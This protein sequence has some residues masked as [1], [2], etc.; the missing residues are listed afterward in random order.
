MNLCKRSW[1]VA[2]SV[3]M[4]GPAWAS[5]LNGLHWNIQDTGLGAGNTALAMRDGYTWP[6]VFTTGIGVYSMFPTLGSSGTHWFQIGQYNAAGN[7]FAGASSPDGR[8]AVGPRDASGLFGFVSGK[9]GGWNLLPNSPTAV[10][11]DNSGQ[12]L[13]GT[14]SG[15]LTGAPSDPFTN[16]GQ[17][18]IT[19]IATDPL[20]DIAVTALNHSDQTT[21]FS[22]YTTWTGWQSAAIPYASSVNQVVLDDHG[23][24]YVLDVTQNIIWGFNPE[25]GHWQSELTIGSNITKG[26]EVKMAALDNTVG[27]AWI[28]SS[29]NLIYAYETDGGAWNQSPVASNVA[30]E[31]IGLAFDYKDQPV[32]SYAGATDLMLAYD[33]QMTPEPASAALMLLAVGGLLLKRRRVA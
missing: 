26:M 10:A 20:G 12:L 11:F 33:P 6:V 31:Q 24:P 18:A 4:A 28:D 14:V 15:A 17:A 27:A 29:G 3:L 16:N 19:S 2:L 13:V 9:T 30:S 5:S 8:V 21:Q 7:R 22:E 25:T 32:I 1:I 23:R